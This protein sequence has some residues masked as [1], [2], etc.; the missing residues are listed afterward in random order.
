M[1]QETFIKFKDN[2]ASFKINEKHMG[3][4]KTGRYSGFD[5]M[6]TAGGMAINIGHAGDIPKTLS[7]QSQELNFGSVLLPTGTILHENANIGLNISVNTGN[8]NSR[9][10]YIIVDHTYVEVIGGQAATY[11][12]IQ[13]PGD[14]TEPSL[15]DT[16][17]QVL[18]GKVTIV[19]EGDE[20]TDLTY[21]QEPVPLLGDN[22]L[23]EFYD[24]IKNLIQSDIDISIN[25][26]PSS[27]TAVLG[28][29][30]LATNTEAITG[31]DT[32]KAITAAAL[33]AVLSAANFVI[34]GSYVHTDV[35]FTTARASKLD[36]LS[37]ANTAEVL[38]GVR[39]DVYITPLEAKNSGILPLYKGSANLT[40]PT[41]DSLQTITF[42][43]I[44]TD[45]FRVSY[46][47][48]SLSVDHDTD[49]DISTVI[50]GNTKT[51]ISFEI[52]IR[53]YVSAAQ[54]LRIV[55]A[56]YAL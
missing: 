24:N 52:S 44:G 18:I 15:V 39:D 33:A 29:I 10:D 49:N 23:Q 56:L 48:E 55:Y 13:G 16:T 50:R 9:I 35:N 8:S 27:T 36:N 7:D 40:D 5:L 47:I 2:T 31:D 22:T 21:I 17:T 1:A 38:A 11:S 19:P 34:D 46:S 6:T 37:P 42:P 54:N 53:E 32:E 26:I 3:I 14:G 45:S 28:L 30:M 12:I 25:N 41:S 51:S 43:D 4:F 20:F